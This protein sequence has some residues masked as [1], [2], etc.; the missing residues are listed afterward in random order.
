MHALQPDT[1]TTQV[2]YSNTTRPHGGQ[3]LLSQAQEWPGM[4]T[5][6]RPVH[7]NHNLGRQLA[8]ASNGLGHEPI[9]RPCAMQISS[10]P[11]TPT[12]PLCS[13]SS[14]RHS[15]DPCRCHLC[16]LP[17]LGHDTTHPL[18]CRLR[19]VLKAGLCNAEPMLPSPARLLS[20]CSACYSRAAATERQP[21]HS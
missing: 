12:T 17:P 21:P 16:P 4:R 3:T 9:R 20:G 19:R 7:H 1:H 18:A 14:G 11:H 10:M 5:C 8:Q 13:T 2:S 15:P 6:W